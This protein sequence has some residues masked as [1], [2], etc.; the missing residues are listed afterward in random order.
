LVGQADISNE[1]LLKSQGVTITDNEISNYEMGK[2]KRDIC[3]QLD[4]L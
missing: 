4:L 1:T 3:I 2:M